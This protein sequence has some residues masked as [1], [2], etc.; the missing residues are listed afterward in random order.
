HSGQVRTSFVRTSTKL[1][2]AQPL[3]LFCRCSSPDGRLAAPAREAFGAALAGRPI[4]STPT[5]KARTCP[6]PFPATTASSCSRA[7]RLPVTWASRWPRPAAGQTPGT[8]AATERPAGSDGSPANSWT[9]SSPPCAA[10]VVQDAAAQTAPAIAAAGAQGSAEVP[11]LPA[12]SA[13][14][15]AELLAQPAVEGGTGQLHDRA[16]VLTE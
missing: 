5:D 1:R 12:S 11:A 4:E 8:S 3:G 10:R 7:R 16:S 6:P 2:G 13:R 15:P 14:Q 9:P